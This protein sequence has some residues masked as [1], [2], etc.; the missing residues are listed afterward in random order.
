MNHQMKRHHLSF[1]ELLQLL[2]DEQG[3]T[4]ALIQ[5]VTSRHVTT[6]NSGIKNNKYEEVPQLRIKVLTAEYDG[7]ARKIE[8]FLRAVAYDVPVPYIIL[9]CLVLCLYVYYYKRVQYYVEMPKCY[10]TQKSRNLKF[11]GDN[12]EQFFGILL[13]S[14]YHSVLSENMF[15]SISE[16]LRVPLVSGTMSQNR[17][18]ELKRIYA[19]LNNR[20]Y[21]RR[22]NGA[23]LRSPQLQNVYSGQANNIQLQNMDNGISEWLPVYPEDIQRQR[24]EQKNRASRNAFQP[25]QHEPY[26]NNYVASYD[27][28]EKLAGK[29]IR[30]T[31]TIRNVRTQKLP[32]M[33]VEEV[34]K[35]ER[36]FL[37][38]YA[39]G[40]R[41]QRYSQA[42]KNI[43]IRVPETVQKYNTS[44][45]SVDTLDKLLSSY[46]LP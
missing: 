14:G 12:T 5:M 27:L 19:D 20:L 40:S 2:I 44:M 13:F 1:Y 3:T 41:V 43:K 34:K 23:I 39:M 22:R 11:D 7:G 35:K 26:F 21:S 33:P 8:Q 38:T 24:Q 10:A 6:N 29:K 16:D 37:A 32:I 30:A 31:R 18:Q 9:Q 25:V 45:G 46:G 4:E 15:W 42:Q 17:F 36:D 28:L